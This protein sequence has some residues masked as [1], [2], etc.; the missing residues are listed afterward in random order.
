MAFETIH[1]IVIKYSDYKESD[2]ILSVLTVEQGFI[3][4]TARGCRK[5]SSQLA[6][7]CEICTYSE[8]VIYS[9]CGILNVSTASV[10]ESFYPIRE[11]YNKFESAEQVLHMTRILTCLTHSWDDAFK[12]CYHTLSYIAYTDNNPIDLELCFAVKF[13]KLAGYEPKLVNCV[14][15]GKDLRREKEL[16]FSKAMGGA[17]CNY[18]GT[19]S[20]VVAPLTL[21]AVRRMLNLPL[22]DMGK[23]RLPEHTRKE[24]ETIIYEY[25]EYNLEQTVKIR[26][27]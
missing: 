23:V 2:R 21:E 1:G 20:R 26:E 19:G 8:F 14:L 7:A 11:D 5:K 18:C 12:L 25:A 16:R 24:L 9:R 4:L 10:L 13:L 15:C 22:T 6:A 27:L 3:T 17:M